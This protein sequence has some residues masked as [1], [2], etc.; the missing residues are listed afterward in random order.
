MP[1][2]FPFARFSKMKAGDKAR[3]DWGGAPFAGGVP[4][5]MAGAPPMM[6]GKGTTP[7]GPVPPFGVAPMMTPGG[8]AKEALDF[9][10]HAPANGNGAMNPFPAMGGMGAPLGPD[11]MKI[12][13]GLGPMHTLWGLGANAAPKSAMETMK[14]GVSAGEA[15]MRAWERE[16]KDL[17]AFL[18]GG[19]MGGGP[20]GPWGFMPGSEA[21]KDFTKSHK[22]MYKGWR[23]FGNVPADVSGYM[24]VPGGLW[25]GWGFEGGEAAKMMNGVKT[26]GPWGGAASENSRVWA[27]VAGMEGGYGLKEGNEAV[28]SPWGWYFGADGEGVKPDQAKALAGLWSY[29]GYYGHSPAVGTLGLFTRMGLKVRAGGHGC[30]HVCVCAS[31][32]LSRAR[33][34]CL[35]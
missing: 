27:P 12:T 5:M 30:V 3:W 28:Y 34:L 31:V 22:D 35:S 33:A 25:G 9:A 21:M 11:G 18:R 15:W 16:H 10:K 29:Q 8:L 7:G 4:P 32:S 6:A 1:N 2:P 19:A 23:P 17:P 24:G 13:P 26:W 20:A 14:V